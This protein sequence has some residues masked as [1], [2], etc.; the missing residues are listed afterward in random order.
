MCKSPK[1][2]NRQ[3]LIGMDRSTIKA[4]DFEGTLVRSLP[5]KRWGRSLA[6]TPIVFSDQPDTYFAVVVSL[7]ASSNRSELYVYDQRD[8]LVYHELFAGKYPAVAAVPGP[9]GK[10]EVLLVGGAEGTVTRYRLEEK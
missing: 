9:D 6:A 3:V 7:L 5:I 1:D 8:T 10:G 2:Q 4:Y